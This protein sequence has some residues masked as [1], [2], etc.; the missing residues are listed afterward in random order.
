ML[1]SVN[2]STYKLQQYYKNKKQEEYLSFILQKWEV[3]TVLQYFIKFRIKFLITKT[4][5]TVAAIL[6]SAKANIQK[7]FLTKSNSIS[8]ETIYLCSFIYR[9]RKLKNY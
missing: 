8:V 7:A 4:R 9:F 3:L 1:L 5:Q 6:T 2:I